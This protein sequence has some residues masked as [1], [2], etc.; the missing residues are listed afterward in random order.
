MQQSRRELL[1][2][3]LDFMGELDDDDARNT[4]ERMLVRVLQTIWLKHTWSDHLSPDPW[5]ITTVANQRS[6]ALPDHFGRPL[7]SGVMRNLTTGGEI[8]VITKNDVESLYPDA[9]TTFET[10]APPEYFF[11][12]GTQPVSTQPAS[13]GDALEV[14]SNDAADATIKVTVIGEDVNGIERRKTV[15]LTGLAPVAVGTFRK[16]TTFGKAYPDGQ[17]PTTEGTSSVGEVTLRK[18]VGA[19]ALETLLADESSR[20]RLVLT[21]YQ[22]PDASTASRCR[23]S[24]RRGVRSMT[25]TRCRASGARPSSKKPAWS[26]RSTRAISITRR[27][28]RRH[29]R[30]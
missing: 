2:E 19:V 3:L 14:V 6:Y 5:L 7:P 25:A 24:G 29:V 8:R 26:G 30:D 23:S 10:A 1:D 28:C 20:E 27:S 16:I 11:I 22:K 12:G 4:A 17:D 15:T 9:G 18:V 21:L 13:T